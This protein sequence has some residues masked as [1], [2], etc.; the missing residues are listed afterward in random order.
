MFIKVIYN[1][2]YVLVGYYMYIEV[3][4]LCK[5]GDNVMIGSVVFKLILSVCLVRFFYYMYGSYIGIFNIYI[6]MSII[7]VMN[8]VWILSGD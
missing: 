8:R 3:F 5:K 2:F 6:R 7:G 4:L 1:I